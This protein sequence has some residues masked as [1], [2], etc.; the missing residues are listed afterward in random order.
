MARQKARVTLEKSAAFRVGSG[1]HQTSEGGLRVFCP[2]CGTENEEAATTCKKCG[3]SL[4][5]AAA[6]KFK[7]TML[8]MNAPAGLRPGAPAP[9]APAPGAP[10]PGPAMPAPMAAPPPAAAPGPPAGSPRPQLKGTM[11][12]VAPPS[13]GAPA[14]QH[15]PA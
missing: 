3:F 11:L 13:M 10:A 4:K 15:Q 5:G 8:M 6:P 1:P 14:P 12:G 9:G 2:N 7:G